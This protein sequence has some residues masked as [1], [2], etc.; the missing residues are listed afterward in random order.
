[1]VDIRRVDHVGIRIRDKERSVSFYEQLGFVAE[2]DTGFE[3]GHP[4]IMEH[5][6]G[7]VLN[8]LGPA[9]GDR[10]PNILMDVDVKH[11][12][13]THVALR[14]GSND[15]LRV[16]REQREI[17]ITGTMKFGNLRALFVRD[18]DGTVIEFDERADPAS[19]KAED[20]PSAY[21][22]HP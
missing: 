21:A 1:M 12:G 3:H 19:K 16:F 4:I 20:D 7:V 10:G 18:P 9:T 8:L 14:V 15:E 6:S 2:T 17:E 11:P 22:K 5:P 13:I